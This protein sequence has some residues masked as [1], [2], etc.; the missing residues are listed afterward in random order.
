MNADIQDVEIDTHTSDDDIHNEDAT[1]SSYFDEEEFEEE[2]YEEFIEN[3]VTKTIK[4]FNNQTC[5]KACI[6]L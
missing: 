5:S 1:M 3:P 2:E 6:L 4:T